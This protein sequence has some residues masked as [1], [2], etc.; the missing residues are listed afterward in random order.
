MSGLRPS[1]L[2]FSSAYALRQVESMVKGKEYGDKR[3]R[4]WPVSNKTV[5]NG[6]NL[7]STCLLTLIVE[8]KYLIDKLTSSRF[9]IDEQPAEQ[10]IK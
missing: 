10:R 4:K 3:K 1:T 8:N 5:F 9:I 6:R 7:I 2:L